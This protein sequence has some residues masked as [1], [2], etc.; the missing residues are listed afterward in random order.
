LTPWPHYSQ[1]D[2]SSTPIDRWLG[3]TQRRSGLFGEQKDLFSLPGFELRNDDTITRLRAG[4]SK[5][6]VGL[7]AE[8]RN[9]LV[10]GQR[11]ESSLFSNVSR[12]AMGPKRLYLLPKLRMSVAI[13]PPPYALIACKDITS[14]LSCSQYLRITLEVHPLSV[15][16]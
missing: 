10:S 5:K 6:L 15:K 14:L 7:R 8:V 3:V 4:Q 1:R 16:F 2:S 13:R 9:W 12:Q 11:S